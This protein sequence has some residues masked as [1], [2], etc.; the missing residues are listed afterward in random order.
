M[1]QHILRSYTEQAAGAG[2]LSLKTE[3]HNLLSCSSYIIPN[4]DTFVKL[5]S[6]FFYLL[7]VNIQDQIL[8]T[9]YDL[10]TFDLVCTSCGLNVTVHIHLLSIHPSAVINDFL[11]T[12]H[13][14]SMLCDLGDRERNRTSPNRWIPLSILSN[15]IE[16][17]GAST[18]STPVMP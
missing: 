4:S 12:F 11:Y 5:F 16:T 13:H 15:D 18:I 10:D 14:L 7:T 9:I 17:H 8:L 6:F 1:T 3:T 2:S